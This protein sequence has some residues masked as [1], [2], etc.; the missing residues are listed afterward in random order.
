MIRDDQHVTTAPADIVFRVAA[1]VERWPEI[2]PHYRWVR[3]DEKDGFG[4]GVVEMAAWRD[5]LGPIRWPTWWKSRMAADADGP[6]VRYHHIDGI[7]AGMD[8]EW[9]FLP[10]SHGTVVRIVHEWD[11]PAWPLVGRFAAD[12]VIGPHFVSAIAQ[13][14]LKGVCAEAERLAAIETVDRTAEPDTGPAEARGT[15]DRQPGTAADVQ[16]DQREPAGDAA[17]E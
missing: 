11:G 2:L 7:T 15:H 6:I 17:D 9:L 3:F 8:V 4:Q 13:R 5:F 1:G 16:V 10:A 12:R 14:T